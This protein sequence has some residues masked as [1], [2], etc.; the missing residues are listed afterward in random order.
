MQKAHPHTTVRDFPVPPNVSYARVEPWSGDPAGPY[1]DAVWMPF[2]RGSQPQRFLV[3]PPIRS[4]DDVVPAP[5]PPLM[6]GK[7][8]SLRCL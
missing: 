6:V 2:V 5:A 3:G 1:P 8:A 4:F 7:C